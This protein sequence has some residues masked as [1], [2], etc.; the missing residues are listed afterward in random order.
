[1]T[2]YIEVADLEA[3]LAKVE[4]CGGTATMQPVEVAPEVV[5]AAFKDPAGNEIRLIRAHG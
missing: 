3:A 2:F 4:Q 5:V 1:M